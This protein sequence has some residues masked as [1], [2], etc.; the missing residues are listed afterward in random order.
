M[1][2]LWLEVAKEI[3]ENAFDEWYFNIHAKQYMGAFDTEECAKILE[4]RFGVQSKKPVQ[5]SCITCFWDKGD[6]C[7]CPRECDS[8]IG[9]YT[10]WKPKRGKIAKEIN[11]ESE[12][13][14]VIFRGC[15]EEQKRWG[16]NTGDVSSLIVGCRY[17]VE[18]EEVHSWHTKI[19]LVGREGSFNSVCFDVV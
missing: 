9:N 15:T 18:R 5:R 8:L 7:A 10:E 1:S 17:V 12:K 2:N 16:N 13:K 14:H 4:K 11:H 6:I 19:F 3:R